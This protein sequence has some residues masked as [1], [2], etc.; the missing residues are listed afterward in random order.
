MPG[1][2]ARGSRGVS[3]A[4]ARAGP[5]ARR[6]AG[7]VPLRRALAA[8]DAQSRRRALLPGG[9]CFAMHSASAADGNMGAHF[10]A[11]KAQNPQQVTAIERRFASLLAAHP[12][13]LPFYL[14]QAVSYLRSKEIP[15]NW[16]ELMGDLRHWDHPERRVQQRWARAF[17]AT[18]R[19]AA[20]KKD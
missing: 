19:D 10:A 4:A 5:A 8:A 9:L 18:S 13:D 15:I 16:H 14:R 11:A 1:E 7:H 12:D 3:R 17:W 20:D 6:R 2:P